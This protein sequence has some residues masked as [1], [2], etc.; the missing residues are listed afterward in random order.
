MLGKDGNE[1][2]LVLADGP[3]NKEDIEDTKMRCE[4]DDD[5]EAVCVHEKEPYRAVLYGNFEKA[6]CAIDPELCKRKAQLASGKGPKKPKKKI[7]FNEMLA[8]SPKFGQRGGPT[9]KKVGNPT[10]VAVPASQKLASATS[11]YAPPQK[12]MQRVMDHHLSPGFGPGV[13]EETHAIH[14]EFPKVWPW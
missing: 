8:K 6:K 7:N 13:P 12:L 2:K 3:V 9:A 10:Q 4:Q 11:A 1:V 14:M 5:C